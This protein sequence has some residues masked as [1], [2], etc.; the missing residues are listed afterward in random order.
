MRKALQNQLNGERKY[1][2]IGVD[3]E[4]GILDSLAVL[5]DN[6]IYEFVG[7]SNPVE[8]IELVKKNILT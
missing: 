5:F 2:I 8:A 7:I 3:D 1:K 6:S 4:L